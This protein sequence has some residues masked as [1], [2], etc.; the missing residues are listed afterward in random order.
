MVRT[1]AES[2]QS[3]KTTPAAG[4]CGGLGKPK[5]SSAAAEAAAGP[6]AAAVAAACAPG[7]G[8]G[9]G[10]GAVATKPGTWLPREYMHCE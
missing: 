2:K 3:P 6:V 8:G 7:G 4:S 9:G 10:D 1:P 5:R